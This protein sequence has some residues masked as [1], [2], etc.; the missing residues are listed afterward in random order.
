MS[1]I[2]QETIEVKLSSKIIKEIDVFA[3]FFHL[4]RNAFLRKTLK[5]D[6][7]WLRQAISSQ[8]DTIMEYYFNPDKL[9][10][11]LKQ[12]NREVI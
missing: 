7:D 12:E 11:T 3:E 4:S 1:K 10:K 9:L 8:P 5:K 6:L 2:K